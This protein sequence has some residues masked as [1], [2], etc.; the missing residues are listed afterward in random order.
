MSGPE[1][2]SRRTPNGESADELDRRRRA[3]QRGALA[4]SPDE[5]LER[6][7]RLADFATWIGMPVHR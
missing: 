5:V 2:G 1:R 6:I 4:M 3:D 7:R